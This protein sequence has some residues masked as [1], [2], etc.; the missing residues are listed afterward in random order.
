MLRTPTAIRTT[1]PAMA[2]LLVAAALS[3]CASQRADT[4][5]AQPPGA[6]PAATATPTPRPTPAR[7][8]FALQVRPLLEE[9][10]TPCHFPGGRMYDRM[11]FDRET[12]I[13][14][15]G[16]SMLTR[17]RDPVDQDLLRTFLAQAEAEASP[18]P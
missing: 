4:H 6:A 14:V 1:A 5:P 10:C 12:T 7:I 3:G 15:L 8:D 2:S 11:P 17:L 18:V 13:R 16:E 9:K